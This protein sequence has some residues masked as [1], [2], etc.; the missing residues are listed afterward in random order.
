MLDRLKK[1]LPIMALVGALVWLFC[2]GLVSYFRQPL[3]VE[4]GETRAAAETVL[5]KLEAM[6]PTGPNDRAFRIAL[7]KAPQEP[8]VA[9]VWLIGPDGRFVYSTGGTAQST[10]AGCTAEE[11]ATD[12]TRR[13]LA[14]LPASA[15]SEEQR[16]WLLAAAAIQRE[17]EHNDILRHLL[18]P[19]RDAQ[20]RVVALMGMSYQASA[21]E[22]GMPYNV[23]MLTGLAGLAVYWLSLPL[24]VLLD[25]RQRW[26]YAVVWA[27]FVLIGNLVAL[28]AY[29]LARSPR[30]HA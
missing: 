24:W 11:L 9:A 10:R 20:G 21:A 26:D 13:V 18:R 16:T 6:Q 1:V 25:A 2:F 19:V 12:E 7:A 22:V 17:G 28:I 5:A 4:T 14:A 23:S 15:L 3:L 30:C 27:L 8:Y 29:L